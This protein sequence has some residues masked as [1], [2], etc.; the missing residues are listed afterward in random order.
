MKRGRAA[1]V[2]QVIA[3]PEASFRDR[4][5]MRIDLTQLC[6][7]L[8]INVLA[9][10]S[11]LGSMSYAFADFVQLNCVLTERRYGVYPDYQWQKKPENRTI[12]ILFDEDKKELYAWYLLPG[13][14]A[15]W[16][17]MSGVKFTTTGMIGYL[18]GWN[19]DIDRQT[20][21]IMLSFPHGSVNPDIE[22][23]VGHCEKSPNPPAPIKKF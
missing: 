15:E 2:P 20:G 13:R 4:D 18:D 14:P 5:D 6:R 23:E 3:A 11:I 12:S 22:E 1:A 21:E 19:Y 8:V 16:T 17:P 9:V 7:I 10:V